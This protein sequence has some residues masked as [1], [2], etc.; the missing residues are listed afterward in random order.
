M[1]MFSYFVALNNQNVSVSISNNHRDAS[2][3][4][5]AN[6]ISVSKT[7]NLPNIP[8][9]VQ[10]P[11]PHISSQ[12]NIVQD[13]QNIGIV[14]GPAISTPV[15]VSNSEGNK[16]LVQNTTDVATHQQQQQLIAAA[17]A[18][19]SSSIPTAAGSVTQQTSPLSNPASKLISA[20]LAN[21]IYQG[22]KSHLIKDSISV[23]QKISIS[24][25]KIEIIGTM[26]YVTY[27][28]F[29]H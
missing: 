13:S 21:S 11:Q 10:M 3:T 26:N 4:T 17:M 23:F 24:L 12:P 14:S 9:V 7:R 1:N 2:N 16:I 29:W 8:L 5:L 19:L 27:I 25:L 28:I 20:S 6:N 18:S 22:K 15:P